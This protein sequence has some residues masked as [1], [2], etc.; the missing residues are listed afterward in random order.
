[1]E[2][3]IFASSG[4]CILHNKMRHLLQ[5]ITKNW[6]VDTYY[7]DI[8]WPTG[9]NIW[10]VNKSTCWILQYQIHRE[11]IY[12][13]F[14]EILFFYWLIKTM[15]WL[16]S[17][18]QLFLQSQFKYHFTLSTAEISHNTKRSGHL[19]MMCFSNMLSRAL[20]TTVCVHRAT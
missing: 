10:E 4:C 18:W 12:V 3:C 15:K 7:T 14:K 1:M 6:P 8:T 19:Y 9:W 16:L 17:V 13:L 11:A 20:A 5:K 2:I